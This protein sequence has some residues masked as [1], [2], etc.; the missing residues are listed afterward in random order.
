MSV[1]EAGPVSVVWV[2]PVAVA[3]R[4]FAATT[5]DPVRT[6]AVA[7]DGRAEAFLALKRAEKLALEA[8]S[9]LRI[10][11]VV[12]PLKLGKEDGQRQVGALLVE[13]PRRSGPSAER[14]PGTARRSAP[15]ADGHTMRPSSRGSA[16]PPLSPG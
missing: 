14:S 12:G 9:A 10:L 13:L 5:H 2:L 11:A 6:I 1:A 16:R 15:R 7:F 8:G 4:G 3:S